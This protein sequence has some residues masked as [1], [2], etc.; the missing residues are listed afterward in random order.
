MSTGKAFGWILAGGCSVATA[1]YTLAPELQKQQF[2]RQQKFLAQH[3]QPA[4]DGE[5]TPFNK[6]KIE[7]QTTRVGTLP[8]SPR[9]QVKDTVQKSWPGLSWLKWSYGGGSTSSE[10]NE[11]KS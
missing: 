3:S 10:S 8:E 9:E 4:S 11:R 5:K 6:D 7:T 2:E 1:Y